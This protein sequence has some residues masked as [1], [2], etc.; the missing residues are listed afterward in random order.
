MTRA[1]VVTKQLLRAMKRAGCWQV[2]IGIE[3]GN[4][5]ILDFIGKGITLDEVR[6]AATWA[7]ELGLSV[8]GFFML[9]HP[10]ETRSSLAET[11]T[12]A[13]SI[14]LT[15]VVATIATPMPG[16]QFREIAHRYGR[17]KQHDWS[18]LSYWEP[19]FVPN[20][21]T[22]DDLY[23]AQRRFYREFYCRPQV[24][25][26]QLRKVHS[27]AELRKYARNTR[28]LVLMRPKATGLKRGSTQTKG[29]G[30]HAD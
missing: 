26:R 21:L 28:R 30:S 18:E 5:R 4:Q 10:T 27:L 11:R 15:D 25:G 12:F 9:G 23:R 17:L 29:G 2:S 20:G 16:S 19:V 8:K 3:S 7:A 22:E 6:N 14:P 24:L 1:D 13:N